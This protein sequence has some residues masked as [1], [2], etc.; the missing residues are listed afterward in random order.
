TPITAP[1]TAL[2]ED[3]RG[4]LW[5]GTG[6]GIYKSEQDRI[7]WS[8][9]KDQLTLP[10][11]RAILEDAEG[12]MWFGLSGG[13]LASLKEGKLTQYRKPNG[14]GSDFV[15]SLLVDS[16]GAIWMGTSD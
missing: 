16:E 2:Y 15:V 11:T 8:A 6:S 7:V 4:A 9:G 3:R 14:L 5:I 10:D 1:V 12:T 13:G